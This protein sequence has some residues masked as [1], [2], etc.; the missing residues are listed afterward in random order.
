MYNKKENKWYNKNLELINTRMGFKELYSDK[1]SYAEAKAKSYKA[2]QENHKII[3]DRE[4]LTSTL[5]ERT[6]KVFKPLRNNQ[7]QSLKEEQNKVKEI[8]D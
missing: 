4:H 2:K 5:D 6:S 1:Q 8:T 3:N 7:D